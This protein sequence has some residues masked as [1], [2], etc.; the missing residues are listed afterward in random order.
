MN[1]L[2]VILFALTLIYLSITE[3]FTIYVNIVALQGFILFLLAFLNLDTRTLENLIFVASE[4][5]IFKVIVMPFFLFRIIKKTGDAR[6]HE[7]AMPGFYSILLVSI[8]LLLS[9]IIS[10]S[11]NHSF[12]TM[13]YFI[14]SFFTLYTGI[15][16]IFTHKKIFVHL[17]G[18]LV[19]ENAVLLLSLSIG[20]DM[21]ML[22]NIGI[23]LDIFVNVLI[24]GL[25]LMR[26]KQNTQELT[27]LKDE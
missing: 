1:V 25:F 21:P 5:L 13:I 19:I 20:S 23:L 16:L 11:L 9:V 8:G 3:R 14:I 2:L 7:K 24:L 26:L 18:F 22:I 10:Y 4:T 6:V 17:V 27:I 12:S 15:F